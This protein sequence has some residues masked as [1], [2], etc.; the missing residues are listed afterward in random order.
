MFLYL[1]IYLV[2]RALWKIY[3]YLTSNL[4]NKSIYYLLLLLI[5]ANTLM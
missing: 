2:L 1:L 5:S 3:V 4:V